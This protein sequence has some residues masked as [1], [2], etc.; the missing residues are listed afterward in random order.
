MQAQK[1]KEV[2]NYK[3]QAYTK[4]E[5]VVEEG[6]ASPMSDLSE[7]LNKI[8]KD[9]LS[10]KDLFKD[11]SSTTSWSFDTCAPVERRSLLL[12]IKN[13]NISLGKLNGL[14]SKSSR[15][16]IQNEDD[17]SISSESLHESRMFRRSAML[18]MKGMGS[19]RML[20][21]K[22]MGSVRLLTEVIKKIDTP[23]QDDDGND[24]DLL[25]FKETILSKTAFLISLWT[26]F[27]AIIFDAFFVFVPTYAEGI[28]LS[29][30]E[31]GL[32]LSFARLSVLIGNLSV[33]F[34]A[35]KFGNI[36]VFQL[37]MIIMS[38]TMIVWPFCRALWSLL[39]VS[40]FIGFT[41]VSYSL[42]V[43]TLADMY[44]EI[45]KKCFFSLVGFVH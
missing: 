24:I 7:A 26:F 6:E 3:N 23:L 1:I 11:E 19:E 28:G 30:E 37:C 10:T 44:G 17:S 14:I 4:L 40:F 45:S 27:V 8:E 22:G 36:L 43:S 5:K 41:T 16:I 29:K 20:S 32:V 13:T 35:D 25:S 9:P 33:G 2:E 42:Y 18:S 12:S 38:S 31:G 21:M 15:S 34:L 39:I